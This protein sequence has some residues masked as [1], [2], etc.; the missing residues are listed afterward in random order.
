MNIKLFL[1]V[2]KIVIVTAF[3]IKCVKERKTNFEYVL[4]LNSYQS[5]LTP[6]IC[7]F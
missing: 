5:P 3:P 2:L 4:H 7:Q 6:E 1:K